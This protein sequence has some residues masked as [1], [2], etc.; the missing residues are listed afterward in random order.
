ML[1]SLL[2]KLVDSIK[3]ETLTQVP[4]MEQG[5]IDS[6]ENSNSSNFSLKHL[7]SILFSSTIL[8]Q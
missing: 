2:N 6:F 1:E 4:I 5:D 7:V 3:K 8:L